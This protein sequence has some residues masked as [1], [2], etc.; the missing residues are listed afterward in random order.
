M[1]SLFGVFIYMAGSCLP[2]FAP[3]GWRE[4]GEAVKLEMLDAPVPQYS[5]SYLAFSPPS[6]KACRPLFAPFGWR[7]HG[8]AVRLAM[9]DAL[10]PQYL[11]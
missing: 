3:S 9:L 8:E 10:V 7:K 2:L 6:Y 5:H 4:H 1:V 11:Q